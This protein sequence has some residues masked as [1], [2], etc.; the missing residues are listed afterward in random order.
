MYKVKTTKNFEKCVYDYETFMSIKDAQ[1]LGSDV[2]FN[3][4]EITAISGEEYNSQIISGII[5]LDK[6]VTKDPLNPAILYIFRRTMSG[7]YLPL[8]VTM[9]PKTASNII[10]GSRRYGSLS[11]DRE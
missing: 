3:N 2:T 1:D 10:R 8:H 9:R 7:K 6:M 5:P 11:I 4:N